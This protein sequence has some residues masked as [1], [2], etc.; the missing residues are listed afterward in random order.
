LRT[1]FEW[2]EQLIGLKSRLFCLLGLCWSLTA[3]GEVLFDNGLP[4][5]SAGASNT[6][7]LGNNLNKYTTAD[8]FVLVESSNII[9]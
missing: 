7:D 2:S 1:N 5:D 6:S 3:H 9:T 8:N 4:D